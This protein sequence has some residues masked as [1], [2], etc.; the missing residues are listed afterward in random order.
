MCISLDF[1]TLAFR[2]LV[3]GITKDTEGKNKYSYN[4]LFELK[5]VP[6]KVLQNQYHALLCR[7]LRH[8]G[9]YTPVGVTPGV[10][11]I[12]ILLIAQDKY[13]NSTMIPT[14]FYI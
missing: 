10:W 5:I 4:L 3:E 2:Y 11:V 12:M 13:K 9:I 1:L 14:L 6:T 8:A 7:C